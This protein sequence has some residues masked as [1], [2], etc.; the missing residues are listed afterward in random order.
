VAADRRDNSTED[1]WLHKTVDEIV[2]DISEKKST[3]R[4]GS[5]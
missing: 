2:R 5:S 1:E 3:R 4:P